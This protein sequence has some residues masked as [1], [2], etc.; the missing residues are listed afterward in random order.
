MKKK[1]KKPAP[2]PKKPAVAKSTASTPPAPPTRDLNGIPAWLVRALDACSSCA[3]DNAEDRQLVATAVMHELGVEV[4]NVRVRMDFTKQGLDE[5]VKAAKLDVAP[6]PAPV[7]SHAME[8][9]GERAVEPKPISKIY[10]AG[11]VARMQNPPP[12]TEPVKQETIRQRDIRLARERRSEK[13]SAVVTNGAAESAR[14]ADA[15]RE[16][17]DSPPWE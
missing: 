11:E 9:H 12:Q 15:E 2:S 8:R 14:A 6:A 3:L 4:L 1:L 5:V 17:E 10:T 16:D 7:P 13:S